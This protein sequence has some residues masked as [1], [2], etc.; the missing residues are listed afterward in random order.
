MLKMFKS[1]AVILLIAACLIPAAG[2]TFAGDDPIP[3]SP[4]EALDLVED[5]ARAWEPDAQLIYLENDEAVTPSGQSG[6]WGYL[7]HSAAT[8]QSRGYSVRDGQIVAASDLQFEFEAPPLPGLWVDAGVALTAAEQKA[9]AKY[10]KE[11]G[12]EATTLLLVRGGFDEKTP[13]MTTWTVIYTSPGSPSLFVLVDAVE[14]KVQKT[15]R[16]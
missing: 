16:G 14:G 7:F 5:A 9:G 15:W 4:R 6:R 11:F 10:R 12:G 13:D 3:F 8:D 2:S 1:R